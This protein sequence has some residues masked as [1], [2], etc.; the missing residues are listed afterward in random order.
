MIIKNGRPLPE[1]LSIPASLSGRLYLAGTCD[2]YDREIRL[3][4]QAFIA[5]EKALILHP[6]PDP[7]I[8]ANVIFT[9]N[10]TISI[11]EFANSNVFGRFLPLIIYNMHTIR[12]YDLS[13]AQF[14]AIAL[15]ELA[16]CL[17]AI[18]DENAVNDK[19]M[20]IFRLIWPSVQKTDVYSP[21][22][23]EE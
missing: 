14:V 6:S 15:E 2:L 4:N 1:S 13:D 8:Y 5:V 21:N 22:S 12:R 18:N 9:D 17:W 16:H 3:F 7:G 11:Q 10:D 20:D 23:T 19:V